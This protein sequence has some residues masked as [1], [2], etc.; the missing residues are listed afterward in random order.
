VEQSLHKEL[1]VTARHKR[2]ARVMEENY[3]RVENDKEKLLRLNEGHNETIKRIQDQLD[4][5]SEAH[6][7]LKMDNEQL[8]AETEAIRLLRDKMRYGKKF[9]FRD[10]AIENSLCHGIYRI[11]LASKDLQLEKLQSKLLTFKHVLEKCN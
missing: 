4:K 8:K 6:S 10:C 3:R 11:D 9:V 5:E 7:N 2:D 1:E